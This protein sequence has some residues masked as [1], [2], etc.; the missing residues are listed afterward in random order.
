MAS[1]SSY[2]IPMRFARALAIVRAIPQTSTF[3]P[4]AADKLQFYGLYK[5]ATEGDVNI[6]RPSSRQI[7]DYAK[8][9]ILHIYIIYTEMLMFIYNCRKTWSRMK[10][11]SPVEAQK[12]Y[13]ESLIQLLTEVT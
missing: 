4:V 9:Y 5:Q 12:L 7:V 13:V 10:G 8:W 11:M 1:N 2:T 6:P 3:Q